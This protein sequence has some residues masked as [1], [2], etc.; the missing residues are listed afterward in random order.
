[1]PIASPAPMSPRLSVDLGSPPTH[2]REY[3]GTDGASP[4][5]LEGMVDSGEIREME[6]QP[7]A[8]T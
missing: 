6:H 5:Y 2:K 3:S 4:S 1:M 7:V 8:N